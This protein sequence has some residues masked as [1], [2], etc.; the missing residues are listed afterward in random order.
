M[1][2]RHQYHHEGPFRR[3]IS[4][5]RSRPQ[6]YDPERSSR[7]LAERLRASY[8][9]LRADPIAWREELEERAAWDPMLVHPSDWQ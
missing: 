3:G 6:P 2:T 8:E 5:F 1:T 9:R 4:R 7:A